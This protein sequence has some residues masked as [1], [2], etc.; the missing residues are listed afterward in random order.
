MEDI[1]KPKP[2]QI[3]VEKPQVGDSSPPTA[4]SLPGKA[5]DCPIV[6]ATTAS[7]SRDL[8]DGELELLHQEFLGGLAYF[9]N[10]VLN[11]AEE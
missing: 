11:G 1:R 9:E 6:T 8:T 4:L 7:E 10:H 5:T 2:S 3:K